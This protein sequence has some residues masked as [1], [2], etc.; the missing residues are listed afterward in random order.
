MTVPQYALYMSG[1]G[2]QTISTPG[3]AQ[4]L[5]TTSVPA[6]WVYATAFHANTG[7]VTLG[8]STTLASSASRVGIALDK[9]VSALIPVSNLNSIWMDAVVSTEGISYAYYI[10]ATP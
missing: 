7:I 4:Q 8:I 1:N 2:R 10:T 5:S 9:G 6:L 3:V